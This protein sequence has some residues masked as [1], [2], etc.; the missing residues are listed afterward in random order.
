MTTGRLSIYLEPDDDGY[1]G[2]VSQMPGLHVYG[3]TVPETL[4]GLAN[5]IMAYEKSLAKHGEP[6]VFERAKGILPPGDELPEVTIRRMRDGWE[7]RLRLRLVAA[8]YHQVTARRRGDSDAARAW[9]R[10]VRLLRDG[11]LG[12]R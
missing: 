12:L 3:S 9:G 7:D 8:I 11:I 4:A 1:H 2:Y 5:C 6:S 10:Q